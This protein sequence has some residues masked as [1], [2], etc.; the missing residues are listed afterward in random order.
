MAVELSNLGSD[1]KIESSGKRRSVHVE[2]KM[3]QTN[4]GHLAKVGLSLAIPDVV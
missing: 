2:D 3:A 4:T 1:G